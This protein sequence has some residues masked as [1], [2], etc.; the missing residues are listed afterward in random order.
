MTSYTYADIE[1]WIPKVIAADRTV[2]IIKP[3]VFHADYAVK[4]CTTVTC[5]ADIDYLVQARKC[6]AT[7]RQELYEAEHIRRKLLEYIYKA[8]LSWHVDSIHLAYENQI[9]LFTAPGPQCLIGQV[10]NETVVKIKIT[11]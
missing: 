1:A 7:T 9:V 5:Q 6:Q 2:K 10:N 4:Q 8:I 3:E 11:S